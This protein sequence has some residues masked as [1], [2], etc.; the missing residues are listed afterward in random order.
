MT[1]PIRTLVVDDEPLAREGLRV[2]LG[3][4]AD[5]EIVGEAVDGVAAV[6][7]IRAQR[8]DL[9]F[10]D[11]QMPG[12][13]GFDVLEEIG[14]IHLPVVIFVTAYDQYAIKAFEVHALDYL[15][16][17]FSPARLARALDRARRQ[18]GSDADREDDDR[19]ARL[20]SAR[21]EPP[22]RGPAY[23]TRIP[24]KARDRFLLLKMDEVWW[25]DAAQNYVELHARGGTFLVRGTMNELEARL[26][27]AQFARI[28]RSTVVNL[29]RVRDITPTWNGDFD[30]VLHDGTALKLSR[31]YR[32]RV[33]GLPKRGDGSDEPH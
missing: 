6:D 7:A 19:L 24:V 26:D 18:L 20:L 23:L 27:P 21:A 31:S 25:I 4:E 2:S 3:H 33:L 32:D 5:V 13:S 29:D 1:R 14:G 17:P 10:L 15:L 12:L 11:V 9:V 16:K 8:P 28:H 30:V 22:L